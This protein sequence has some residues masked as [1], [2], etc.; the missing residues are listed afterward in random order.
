MSSTDEYNPNSQTFDIYKSL[1]GKWIVVEGPDRIGK[2]TLIRNLQ[3][4]LA[5]SGI[6]VM[7]NGFPR[8]TTP[9]G[10][11]IDK[12]L[13]SRDHV[14]SGKAQTLLFIADM[15]E[16]QS[17]ISSWKE[18]NNGTVI[19]D[20]YKM[21]TYSYAKAQFDEVKDKNW[22]KSAI[23]LLPQPDVYIFLTPEDGNLDFTINRDKFGEEVTERKDIQ[24]R[25]LKN[26]D[27]FASNH[28]GESTVIRV[29]VGECMTPETICDKYV[30]PELIRTFTELRQSQTDNGNECLFDELF[31]PNSL[32]FRG[33]N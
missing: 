7:T 3:R 28:I 10:V 29:T 31:I 15:L 13:K 4:K 5:E 11:L 16:A 9:I 12:T 2:T 6:N 20:R 33:N 26:M 19:T 8:R 18:M 22:I 32:K 25:V 21:S 1:Q 30:L 17:E 14:V 24:E 27:I 23:D